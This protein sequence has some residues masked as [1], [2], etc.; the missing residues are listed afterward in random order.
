MARLYCGV[1]PVCAY[2]HV[3]SNQQQYTHTQAHHPHLPAHRWPGF[4][5]PDRERRLGLTYRG[6]IGRLRAALARLHATGNLTVSVVG[7]SISAGAG[8]VDAHRC[9]QGTHFTSAHT[10]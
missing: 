7:G 8:A 1:G 6:D 5:V 10:P 9:E 4:I 2:M 3:S